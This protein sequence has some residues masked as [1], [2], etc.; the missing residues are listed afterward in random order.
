VCVCVCV[1]TRACACVRSSVCMLL[2]A[3]VR[4]HVFVCVCLGGAGLVACYLHLHVIITHLAHPATLLCKTR[5]KLVYREN[6]RVMLLSSS[7]M[8]VI[9]KPEKEIG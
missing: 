1:H 2:G 3:C 9:S 7:I 8:T 5:R 6:R 4:A